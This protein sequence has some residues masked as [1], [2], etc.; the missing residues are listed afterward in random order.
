MTAGV[1]I[2]L[3]SFFVMSLVAVIVSIASVIVTVAGTNNHVDD[4]LD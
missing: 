1:A 4:E 2:A 3:G